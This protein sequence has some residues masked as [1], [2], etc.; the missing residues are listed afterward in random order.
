MDTLSPDERVAAVVALKTLPAAKS[1]LS[2]LPAPLRERL[3]RCMAIDTLAALAPA[4]DRVVVVSDQ[5]DLP[6]ALLRR[7]QQIS[8]V[9]EPPAPADADLPALHG[10]SLNRALA[11]ADDLLR[12][13]GIQAVLACVGDLPALRTTSVG[14][15]IAASRGRPRSFLPDHDGHGSTMLVARGVPLDPRYGKE[16]LSG[17]AVGS[18][19]RHQ[20]SGALPLDLGE[21]PDAR[22]DVDTLADLR[23]AH[24]LGVGPATGS[25]LDPETASPGRYLVVEVLARDESGMTVLAE[26]VT[27]RVGW[28]AYDGDPALRVPGRRLHAARVADALRCW[29]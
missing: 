19:I 20:R 8:V 5:L 21:L 18:A 2:S 13:D 12:A 6:A 15:V 1:R 28:Q 9:A 3:A 23:I 10:G 29:A 22:W 25:L 16:M 14:Q 4:V 27:A 24:R 26:R 17:E 7:G 11:H